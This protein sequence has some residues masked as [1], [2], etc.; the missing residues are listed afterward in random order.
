MPHSATTI[1]CGIAR[2]RRKNT[3]DAR[4]LEVVGDDD[5]DRQRRGVSS[6]SA[7]SRH[8]ASV[9][10]VSAVG[11]GVDRS[12]TIA[13]C[14]RRPSRPTTCGAPPSV[15]RD[16]VHR[17]PTFTSR[18]LGPGRYLKAELFQRTGSF[19]ARGALNRVRSLSAAERDARRDQRLGRQP[20]AGA[21]LGGGHRGARCAPRHV[22]GRERGEDRRHARLRGHRRPRRRRGR[23]RR[24][25]GCDELR[26]RDGARRS[27][28]RSTIPS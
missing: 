3:V 23:A 7:A 19:K 10:A 8:L 26:E 21:G 11:R 18:S 13:R 6:A 5:L 14:P 9:M 27:C 24:S 12:S 2:S 16:A 15:I 25:S 17:T 4:A 28:T 22:A 1:R 20:R